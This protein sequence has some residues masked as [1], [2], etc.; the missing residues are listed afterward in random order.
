MP[1]FIAAIVL[2]A[3][4][5]IGGGLIAT[6]AYQAGLNTAVT[7]VVPGSDTVVAPVVIHAYGYGWSPFGFGFGFFGFL[8][9]LFFLFIVFGLI[10]AI[11]FRGGRGR[12]G[13][14]RGGWNSGPGGSSQSGWQE[15]GSREAR[16]HD[17]FE[18]W[19][20]QAHDPS[21]TGTAAP[22]GPATP[23]GPVT[24]AGPA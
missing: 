2:I 22:S 6:T 11:L 16:F 15:P 10:R 4:L 13:W 7:T 12:G 9:T 19:H 14:G 1:R 24:P 20:R 21:T 23:A 5:A 8:A 18:A 17:T 3:V